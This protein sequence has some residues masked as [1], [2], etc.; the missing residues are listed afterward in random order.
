MHSGWYR[1]LWLMFLALI[2]AVPVSAQTLLVRHDHDPWGSCEGELHITENGIRYETEKKEHQRDWA[3]VDVQ[4]FDRR[5]AERFSVLSYED[6]A[7]H[8]GLDRS[9]DFTILPGEMGLEDATFEQI[10]QHIARP[11]TDRVPR[12]V[13][14][15]YQVAV[16]H[17]HVFGGCE[18]TLTFGDGW[19]VYQTDHAEDARNWRR[20]VHIANVWSSNAFE[21]ELR[22]LEENQR[23]FDKAKRFVF[24]LKEPLDR[25]YYEA[26][27][28]EFLLAR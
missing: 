18:G 26:L 25:N 22:V 13:E 12:V 11:V 5:S 19:I 10:E 24:Q 15:E 1:H 8:L 3:W 16:K 2:I 6:L 20:D 4:S 21:L 28:R 7:L 14:P 23:A 27:R 9:F 17:L